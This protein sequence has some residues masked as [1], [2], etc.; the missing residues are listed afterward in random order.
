MEAGSLKG[1]YLAEKL[2]ED[3]WRRASSRMF[4]SAGR[5]CLMGVAAAGAGGSEEV[6]VARIEIGA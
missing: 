1:T 2:C 3:V 6:A 5:R 4:S